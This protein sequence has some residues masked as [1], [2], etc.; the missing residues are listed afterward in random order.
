MGLVFL[1]LPLTSILDCN[2]FNFGPGFL[3]SAIL[4]LL[5]INVVQE[6]EL[7]NS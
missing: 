6:K 2:F 4:L 1:G 5:E 3:Y 7:T